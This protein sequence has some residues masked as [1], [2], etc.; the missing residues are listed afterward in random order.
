MNIP[1]HK[2]NVVIY[3]HPSKVEWM[4]QVGWT[5]EKQ[6]EDK[7]SEDEVNENGGDNGA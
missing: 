4:E 2:D 6:F 3:V 1:M 7:P 5:V